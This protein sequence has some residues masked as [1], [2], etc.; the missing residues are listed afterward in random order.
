MLFITK[1]YVINNHFAYINKK[2]K[3]KQYSLADIMSFL[4]F[5]IAVVCR[6]VWR[7][8]FITYDLHSFN[9]YWYEILDLILVGSLMPLSTNISAISWRSVLLVEETRGPGENHWPDLPQVTAKLYY[10]MLYSSPWVGVE[11]TTS[12]VT[13]T[14]SANAWVVVNPT[15]IRS[16]PLVILGILSKLHKT[17][18]G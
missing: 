11:P 16:Q 2:K 5:P 15:I 18:V 3:L 4:P 17:K 10:I 1:N 8:A 7:T 14:D 12:V 9:G 13:G 6:S